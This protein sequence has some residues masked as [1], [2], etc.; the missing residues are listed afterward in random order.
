[1]KKLIL[2]LAAVFTLGGGIAATGAEA[3]PRDRVVVHTTRTIL[4]RNTHYDRGWHRGYTRG[5]H[6][7]WNRGHHYGWRNHHLTCRTILRHHERIRTCTR[8]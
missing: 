5:H 7:G 1:M 2:A 6:Y 4:H 3:Q 8:W